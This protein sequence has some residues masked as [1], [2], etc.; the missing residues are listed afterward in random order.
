MRVNT[1]Q[2]V[3]TPGWRP[4]YTAYA[5]PPG[6]LEEISEGV[7]SYGGGELARETWESRVA[8]S[9]AVIEA[10]SR[11]TGVVSAA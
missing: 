7:A 4:T 2:V 1:Y 5:V 8:M 9:S 11:G 10:R 6:L 3:Y